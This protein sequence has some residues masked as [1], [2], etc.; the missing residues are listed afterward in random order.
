MKQWQA[1]LREGF[2]FPQ[3][4]RT[5]PLWEAVSTAQNAVVEHLKTSP[6]V[7]DYITNLDKGPGTCCPNSDVKEL[8]LYISDQRSGAIDKDDPAITA[9]FIE[10]IIM[11]VVSFERN[12]CVAAAMTSNDATVTEKVLLT[13]GANLAEYVSLFWLKWY[14]TVA[15]P[16]LILPEET[17]DKWDEAFKR[18]L[19]EYD[20]TVFEHHDTAGLESSQFTI[21]ERST[22]SQAFPAEISAIIGQII[23][24]SRALTDNGCDEPELMD[25]LGALV[26]AYGCPDVESLETCWSLVDEKWIRVPASIRV[27]FVHGMEGGYGHH[28][29][30]PEMFVQVRTPLDRDLIEETMD[31]VVGYAAGQNFDDGSDLDQRLNLLDAAVFMT[32]VRAGSALAFRPAGSVVPNRANVRKVGGKIFVDH[33]S[34]DSAANIYHGLYEKHC[35]AASAA[36]LKELLAGKTV[37][38]HILLHEYSHP[39][40]RTDET[41]DV[42]GFWLHRHD[43]AKATVHGLLAWLEIHPEE[44][45]KTAALCVGRCLRF[46]MNSKLNDPTFEHYVRE[47]LVLF[48]TMYEADVIMLNDE[49]VSV[50]LDESGMEDWLENMHQYVANVVECYKNLDSSGLEQ[51][52]KRFWDLSKGSEA[53]S[54]IAWVNR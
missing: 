24:I 3:I 6:Q 11:P 42:L 13:G 51:L 5:I 27:I 44:T 30:A 49:G 39:V 28:C 41:D 8:V 54:L 36:A 16:Y 25:Y 46:F 33:A 20:Y 23:S 15:T 53:A 17:R 1:V 38:K 34:L 37:E 47:C 48:Y 12:Q 35:Q 40:A 21:G 22:W 32:P 18:L 2:V 4:P 31:G 7:L 52:G 10:N 19:P 50:Y 45:A 9:A 26:A 29:V 14:R 43:E